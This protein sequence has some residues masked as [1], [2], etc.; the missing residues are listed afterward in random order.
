M[1][2]PPRAAAK[3]ADGKRSSS[4]LPAMAATTSPRDARALQKV[5]GGG[6]MILLVGAQRW[7]TVL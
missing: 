7:R 4:S 3:G 2:A 1:C 6:R 5:A